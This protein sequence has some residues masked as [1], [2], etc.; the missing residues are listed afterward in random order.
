MDF[1]KLSVPKSCPYTMNIE[2]RAKPSVPYHFCLGKLCGRGE[3]QGV[4]RVKPSRCGKTLLAFEVYPTRD[5]K[6]PLPRLREE[7]FIYK[8]SLN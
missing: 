6:R 2:K 8:E 7:F 4:T 5:W 1:A 3:N